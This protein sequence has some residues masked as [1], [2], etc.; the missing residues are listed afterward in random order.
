MK[1]RTSIIE[2]F[3]QAKT[4]ENYL[5]VCAPMVRY[6]KVQ[7]RTLVKNYG[8]DLCFTPMILADSFCQ[9]SKAR[10]SEFST[11]LNDTPLIVQ[12]A[13]NS[14]DAFVDASKLVYSYADGVDLNCGC[15][16]KWAMKD[17]YGCALLSKPETICELVKAIKSNL[18]HNFSVSVKIRLLKEIK[19]TISMCQQLEKCGVNFLTV[20]G[21]TPTQ[22]SGDKIDTMGL[23]EVIESVNI[24][25]IAN[26]GIKTLEDADNLYQE[27]KCNGVMAASGILTN[28]G[29]FSGATKTP[30]SCVKLWMDMKDKDV[31]SIS[32]QCYHHHLVFML[33]KVLSKQQKLVFNHLST[34]ETV[35]KYLYEHL[36]NC[37]DSLDV[38]HNLGKF[39]DCEYPYEITSKHS[40]KCRSCGNSTCY[41]IC[42]KYNSN[43]SDGKYFRSCVKD[44]SLD[45][46]DCSIFD[47]VS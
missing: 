30:L 7:F 13:A 31:D 32:F 20:H 1:T 10:S 45:Y 46:M 24:P 18:P 2:L 33:E 14:S 11:T 40:S 29:L 37:M 26:G 9:N 23:Q 21:R 4:N 5:K 43:I 25:I 22:K 16:Q 34:F 42:N 8:V 41:C 47:L 17:G 6:S 35:D 36:I 12:F 15:P 28:P 27:V 44:D 19:K 3:D 39:V 38:K